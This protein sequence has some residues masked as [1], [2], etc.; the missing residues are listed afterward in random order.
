MLVHSVSVSYSGVSVRGGTEKDVSAHADDGVPVP[1]T[2]VGSPAALSLDQG[3]GP[4][5]HNLCHLNRRG[6]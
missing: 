2:P 4:P 5:E 6:N 3:P 1:T